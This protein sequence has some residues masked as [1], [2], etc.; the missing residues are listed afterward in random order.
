M[1]YVLKSRV[2]VSFPPGICKHRWSIVKRFE[3]NQ[4]WFAIRRCRWCDKWERIQ[5]KI[6]AESFT[7]KPQ[8]FKEQ[9]QM[10]ELRNKLFP[11]NDKDPV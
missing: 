8:M 11:P 2:R 1:P 3:E 5:I 10:K 9:I 7:L 4:V 6:D